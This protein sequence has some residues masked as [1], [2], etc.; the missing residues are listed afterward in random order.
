MRFAAH[1]FGGFAAADCLRADPL[2]GSD[3]AGRR[4]ASAAAPVLRCA[5]AS[6]LNIPTPLLRYGLPGRMR[7]AHPTCLSKSVQSVNR[8]TW[9]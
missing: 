5:Q 7:A 9:K 2:C 6:G 3:T 8:V 4:P 1:N